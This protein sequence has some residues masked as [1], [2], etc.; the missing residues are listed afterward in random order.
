MYL[1]SFVNYLGGSSITFKAKICEYHCAGYYDG[2]KK[3][4]KERHK[5]E[6]SHDPRQEFPEAWKIPCREECSR[7]SSTHNAAKEG[8]VKEVAHIIIFFLE[9]TEWAMVGR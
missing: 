4:E 1:F 5:G 3:I 8:N 9:D 7:S 2:K 6:P